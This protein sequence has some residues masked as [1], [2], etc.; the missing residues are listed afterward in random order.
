MLL[1]ILLVLHLLLILE[2]LVNPQ[3]LTFPQN[4]QNDLEHTRQYHTEAEE[5]IEFLNTSLIT[6]KENDSIYKH[7]SDPIINDKNTKG[8]N[9]TKSQPCQSFHEMLFVKENLMIILIPVIIFVFIIVIIFR[10]KL[11]LNIF[12]ENHQKWLNTLKV[13]LSFLL[14]INSLF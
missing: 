2:R 8:Q 1:V 13:V 14:R 4:L 10:K 11:Y 12:N 5:T 6:L 7:T 3:N 9:S